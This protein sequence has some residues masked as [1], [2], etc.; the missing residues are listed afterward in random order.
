MKMF[1]DLQPIIALHLL[2]AD[3]GRDIFQKKET[4]KLFISTNSEETLRYVT[5]FL[6]ILIRF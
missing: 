2:E 1:T 6:A 3:A 5:H 4:S